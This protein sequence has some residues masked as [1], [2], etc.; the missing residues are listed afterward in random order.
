[1]PFTMDTY[2]CI[3]VPNKRQGAFGIQNSRADN[4]GHAEDIHKKHI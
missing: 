4:A 2:K 1:M 3:K